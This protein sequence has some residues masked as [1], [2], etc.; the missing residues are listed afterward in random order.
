MSNWTKDQQKKSQML[1]GHNIEWEIKTKEHKVKSIK[2]QMR[3]DVEWKIKMN[4]NI[5]WDIMSDGK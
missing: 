5:E 2:R 1:K 3:H 4:R